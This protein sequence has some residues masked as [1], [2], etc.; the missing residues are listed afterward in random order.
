MQST[1][2]LLPLDYDQF[3][4][5]C[6]LGVFPSYYEPWGYTPMECAALGLPSITS[7]L[8]GF[9]SYIKSKVPD[10]E[11]KGMFIVERR[12]KNWEESSEQIAD[13]MQY[14]LLQNRR[15]RIDMRNRVESSSLMFDWSQ[16]VRYYWEA[17]DLGLERFS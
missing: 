7:D 8:A 4:R 3:V 9:G 17:H 1:S 5:G 15:E 12:Y 16:L 2:P 13:I 10:H 14:V 6:H 11:Q